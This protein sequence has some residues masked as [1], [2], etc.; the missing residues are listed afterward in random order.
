MRHTPNKNKFALPN[1][2]GTFPRTGSLDKKT[3]S[4]DELS[5]QII[6][7]DNL[8]SVYLGESLA[9]YVTLPPLTAA[10]PVSKATMTMPLDAET[11]EVDSQKLDENMRARWEKMEWLWEANR[12]RTDRKSL[13]QRLNY[14]NILASQLSYLRDPGD[15]PTRIA[16]TQSGRP[17]AA[18]ITDGKALVDRNLYQ[19]TC[20]DPDEAYYLL[21]IINSNALGKSCKAVLCFQL[22]QRNPTLGKAPMEASNPGVQAA[23][24]ET[25]PVGSPWSGSGAGGARTSS[26]TRQASWNRLADFRSRSSGL[27]QCLADDESHCGGD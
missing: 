23:Q 16:Y 2:S 27:P 21:A 22:G 13:S 17:T 10:L 9:P 6:C 25:R 4:V 20:R 7:N 19:V 1:T 15:R 11:G 3:Y 5:G 12:K 18:L 26:R 8:I 14:H 24:E